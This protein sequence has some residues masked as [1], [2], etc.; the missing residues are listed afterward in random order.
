MTERLFILI[1]SVL[2][3]MFGVQSQA[4]YRVDFSQKHFW[5]FA[6]LAVC[7]VILLVLMLAWFVNSVVLSRP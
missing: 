3:A 5:P 1:Q 4:K 6:L 7:F 2:A